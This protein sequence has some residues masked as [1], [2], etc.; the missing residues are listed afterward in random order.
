MVLM[1]RNLAVIIPARL[2]STRF[3][4]KILADLGGKKVIEW[5]IQNA[6]NADVG[7]VILAY[8][9]DEILNNISI[10][11]DLAVKTEPN[12]ANGTLRIYDA[13]SKLNS[14]LHHSNNSKKYKYIINLQGDLPIFDVKILQ[15]LADALRGGQGAASAG[16][17]GSIADKYDIITPICKIDSKEEVNNPNVVKVACG[18]GMNAIYFSRSPVPYDSDQYYKHIGI[19]GF[20][21]DSLKRFISLPQSKLEAYEKLEQ[22]RALESGM[23]IRCIIADSY[24]ISVDTKD[25]LELAKLCAR[26]T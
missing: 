15:N 11:P 5:V 7:D 16:S 2:G 26:T 12:L 14:G 18:S 9:E 17:P 23:K 8:A 6:K 19:Y 21:A 20:Y 25:D 3:P 10:K 13:Y 22:L 1:N 4:G 24:P